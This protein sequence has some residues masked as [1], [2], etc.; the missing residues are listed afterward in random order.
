MLKIEI[1]KQDFIFFIKLGCSN[2]ELAEVFGCSERTVAK[3][4]VEWSLLGLTENNKTSKTVNNKRVCL[5][6]GKKKAL[7]DFSK[8]ASAK[9]GYRSTCR[10]CRSIESKQWYKEN[11]ARKAETSKNYYEANKVEALARSAKRRAK[12]KNAIP[13]WYSIEDDIEFLSLKEKCR[14]LYEQT[15]ILYEVDHIVPLQSDIVCGF[16]CK[17]NWQI[18]TR[19]QNRSKSNK[20]IT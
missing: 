15:G 9:S 14:E 17:E 5:K 16:H 11:T 3:R 18:L 13:S 1:N 4:K 10:K 20:H 19:A 2:K 8:H 6:C 12:L 7:K